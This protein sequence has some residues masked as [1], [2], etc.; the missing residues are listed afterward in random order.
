MVNNKRFSFF[1]MVLLLLTIGFFAF[2]GITQINSNS[3][4]KS[5]NGLQIAVAPSKNS[6][7]L[8]ETVFLDFEVRNNSSTDIQVRGLDLDSNYVKVFI[9][10]PGEEYKQ[11]TH[12]RI[13][14]G[15]WWIFK[16]GQV[17]KSRAGIL[18]N[19]SPKETSTNWKEMEKTHILNNYAFSKPGVYS[20][21]AV[22]GVPNNENPIEV[23]SKPIQI[24]I[25]EPVGED[26]EIWNK[27]KDR[28]DIAYFI[29]EGEFKASKPVE[30]AKLQGEV[31]QII[32]KYPTSL[33]S[34]QMRKSLNKLKTNEEKIKTYKEKM[35]SPH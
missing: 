18:W 5:E 16:A 25:N 35:T 21:K 8:G 13:K 14:E 29:Q 1:S 10:S 19:F 7:L 9:A 24:I 6:Y 2:S 31:E 12:S 27:I 33:I 20:I 34:N 15:R 11:Y 17:V 32:N 26:L 28:A 30:R 4:L 3:F 22:L 23:E